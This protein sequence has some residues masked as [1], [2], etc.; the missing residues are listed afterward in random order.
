MNSNNRRYQPNTQRNNNTLSTTSNNTLCQT[1]SL[2][3]DSRTTNSCS[4]AIVS[5]PQ[6]FAQAKSGRLFQSSTE[7]IPVIGSHNVVI[8]LCNPCSSNTTVYLSSVICANHSPSPVSLK[9]FFHGTV[10]QE[11]RNSPVG[12]TNMYVDCSCKPKA[13]LQCGTRIEIC[14][15]ILVSTVVVNGYDT[16]TESIDGT[17]ILSPDC[18]IIFELC[19]VNCSQTALANVSISWWEVP[20]CEELIR[21]CL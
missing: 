8:Q 5:V 3:H 19:S 6:A 13:C 9:T 16:F 15:G 12:N 14:N 7:V 20:N 11:L 21:C 2:C 4:K 1:E 10:K 17:I 18:P